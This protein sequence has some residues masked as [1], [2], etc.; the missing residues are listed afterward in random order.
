MMVPA[1]ARENLPQ[2]C[3]NHLRKRVAPALTTP[4]TCIDHLRKRVAPALTT[5]AT[6]ID[7]P[8]TQVVPTSEVETNAETNLSRT[9]RVGGNEKRV[10]ERL[11]LFR[12]SS[13]REG[14][15][16][17]EFTTEAKDGLVEHI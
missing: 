3:Q 10:E 12:R 14:T 7:H 1:L 9:K 6:C 4:A 2:K 16:V 17:Y 13:R 11:A 15:E 5:P 8:L